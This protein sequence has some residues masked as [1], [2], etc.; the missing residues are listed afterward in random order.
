MILGE[1]ALA[2]SRLI[3]N[4]VV[5][6][7]NHPLIKASDYET[8]AAEKVIT[9]TRSDYYPQVSGNAIR[10]FARENTRLAATGL[11]NNPSG[12]RLTADADKAE[13]KASA[14]RMR[15]EIKRSEQMQR[16]A[17]KSLELTQARYD[18]GKSSIVDLNQA[19][20]AETQAAVAAASATYEYLIQ[21][22]LLE[23]AVGKNSDANPAKT[24]HRVRKN[25]HA[26][27][28][29]SSK[30]KSAGVEQFLHLRRFQFRDNR[31]CC[32][33][34]GFPSRDLRLSNVQRTA[35]FFPMRAPLR[36]S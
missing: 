35:S 23:Y 3:D 29:N 25:S 1:L 16:N 11:L 18:I 14:A 21:R 19:Q 5:A 2:F 31:A 36:M 28:P 30:G 22:A 24:R 34:F 4:S 17:S 10:A 15:V 26:I 20:L 8:R 12:G 13:A 32:Q 33:C 7:E 27:E 6:L 9:A